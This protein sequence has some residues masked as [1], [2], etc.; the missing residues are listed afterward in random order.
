MDQHFVR[1]GLFEWDDGFLLE[2]LDR[3]FQN[4]KSDC[5]LGKTP[6]VYD[7]INPKRDDFERYANVAK[8]NGYT[9]VLATMNPISV[10]ESVERNMHDVPHKVVRSIIN[11][12][13]PIAPVSG[14]RKWEK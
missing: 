9:V 2:A 6:L 8:K 12:W 10:D 1:N 5:E 13:E 3:N 14:Q 11:R 7:Y 4:F